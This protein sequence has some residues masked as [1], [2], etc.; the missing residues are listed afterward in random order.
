MSPPMLNQLPA[1]CFQLSTSAVACTG[2]SPAAASAARPVATTEMNA[3]QL[4]HVMSATTAI[5]QPADRDG[6]ILA[7]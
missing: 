6:A 1:V 7:A 2:G 3:L 5:E 4:H